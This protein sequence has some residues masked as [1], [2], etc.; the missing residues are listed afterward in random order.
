M[1]DLSELVLEIKESN[2]LYT[3]LLMDISDFRIFKK[4]RV[5]AD[6]IIEKQTEKIDSKIIY[7]DYYNKLDKIKENFELIVGNLPLGLMRKRLVDDKNKIKITERANWLILLNSL[8]KLSENGKGIYLVE[9]PFINSKS[10]FRFMGLLNEKG[11]FVESVFNS[12]E[13]SLKPISGVRPLIIVI[14]RQKHDQI[15]AADLN[16]NSDIKDILDNKLSKKSKNIFQGK[17]F[18]KTKFNG[19][20]KYKISEQLDKL[21]KTYRDFKKYSIKE[22]SEEINI[23]KNFDTKKNAIFIPRLGNSKVVANLDNATLKHQNLIQVVLDKNFVYSKYLALFSNSKIGRLHLKIALS[24]NSIKHI[25]ISAIQDLLVSI[26]GKDLQKK[27]IAS[28]NKLLQLKSKINSFKKEIALNPKSVESIQN[29]LNKMLISLDLLNESDRIL[30]SIREGESKTLEFKSTLR[31]SIGKNVP[32]KVIEKSAL[33]NLAAFLNS[34]GGILLIG[35]DDD[36]KVLGI[37]IDDFKSK[38]DML[39]HVKNLIKRDFD[40]SF[41]DLINYKIVPVSGRNVLKFK[42]KPSDSPVF[43]GKNEE[44]YVRMNPATNKLNGKKLMQ[45]IN[46][47][48]K[49]SE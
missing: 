14:S 43:L 22:I 36:G 5:E 7:E 30:S 16:E 10:G 45:Y 17:F 44:F 35:V 33:K 21:T 19:F 38:D 42:C 32:P 48:F 28:N 18:E 37:E 11:F 47:H 2:N 3:T 4:I 23:G 49:K 6:V 20:G 9:Q 1:T 15:F 12:P 40:P 31:K 8:F 27:I 13:D 24:G 26:P 34:Y 25:N 46:N 29:N 39:K 41:Y